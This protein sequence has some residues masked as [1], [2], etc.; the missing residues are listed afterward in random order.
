MRSWKINLRI[1]I[2]QKLFENGILKI[3]ILKNYLNMEFFKIKFED[4]NFGKLN[5]DKKN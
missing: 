5:F 4:W 3:R 2:L 1:G